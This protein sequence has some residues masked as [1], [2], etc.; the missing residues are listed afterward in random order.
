MEYLDISREII[1]NYLLALFVLLGVASGSEHQAA[2][3]FIGETDFGFTKPFLLDSKHGFKQV[4]FHERQNRLGF[5]I[6]ETAVVF[7]DLYSVFCEHQAEIQAAFEGSALF[8]HGFERRNNDILGRFRSDLIGKIRIRSHCPHSAGILAGISVADAF[9]IHACRHQRCG[10]AVRKDEKRYF[11]P[12]KEIL[13]NHPVTAMPECAVQHH[14]FHCRFCFIERICNDN[15]LAESQPVRLDD[16]GKAVI[17]K[18]L[19]RLIIV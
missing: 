6:S 18:M 19:Y 14:I 2:G 12:H 8:F 13:D 9:M 10:F 4:A 3:E 11:G 17:F 7:D 1:K 16:Y 15:A 5:G